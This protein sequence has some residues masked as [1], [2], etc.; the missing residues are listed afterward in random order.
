MPAGGVSNTGGL[1]CWTVGSFNAY[2]W[3]S[4]KLPAVFNGK[5]PLRPR[6]INENNGL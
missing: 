4:A 1:P 5:R 3:S 2:D 6:T